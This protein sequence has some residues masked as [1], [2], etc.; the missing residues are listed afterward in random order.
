MVRVMK[1]TPLKVVLLGAMLAATLALVGTNESQAQERPNIIFIMSDDQA[2]STLSYMPNV[3]NLIKAKGRTFTNAFNAY[4][5]CCPSRATIQ[6]GQ[7]AHNTGIFGNDPENSG[8]YQVFDQLDLEQSTIATWLDAA[9]Y[10]TLYDGKY[11]NGLDP[12]APGPPGWDEFNTS[13]GSS[14]VGETDDAT[15]ASRAMAHL[16]DAAPRA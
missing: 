1:I 10:R 16:R 14:Q 6:R 5:L 2:E 4:P 9:G 13:M 7:Y 3:Q 15:R 12:S 11:M 8:G